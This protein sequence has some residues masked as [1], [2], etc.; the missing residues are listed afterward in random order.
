MESSCKK[1]I[2]GRERI[3]VGDRNN[4]GWC[5]I[6]IGYDF[7]MNVRWYE[8]NRIIVGKSFIWKFGIGVFWL[9]LVCVLWVGCYRWID[10]GGLCD[11][12]SG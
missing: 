5:V 12:N 11:Y 10:D 1:I 2:L 8:E 7:L 4:L 6:K 9:C 3:F